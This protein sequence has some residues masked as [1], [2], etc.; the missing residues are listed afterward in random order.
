MNITAVVSYLR[1]FG[2]VG[3]CDLQ[4]GQ[5]GDLLIVQFKRLED[6]ETV[7]EKRYHRIQ[8]YILSVE[9][10]TEKASDSDWLVTKMTVPVQLLSLSEVLLSRIFD[11]LVIDD[12]CAVAETC[13]KFKQLSDPVFSSKFDKLTLRARDLVAS[14]AFMKFGH[15]ITDLDVDLTEPQSDYLDFIIDICGKNLRNLSLWMNGEGSA[16]L[17]RN[18]KKKLM[19]MLSHLQRLEIYCQKFFDSETMKDLFSSCSTLE[20]LSINSTSIADTV[21]NRINVRFP[22][23][24]ELKLHLNIAINDNGFGTLLASNPSIKKLYVDECTGLSSHAINIIVH[25]LPGLE[26]LTLGLLQGEC[27]NDIRSLGGLK[28]LKS[29]RILL[30]QALPAMNVV[31]EAGIQIESLDLWYIHLS[32]AHIARLSTMLSIKELSI[33]SSSL[34]DAHLKVIAEKLPLLTK[35]ML[36]Y[37]KHVT[38]DGLENMLLNAKRL[39]SLYLRNMKNIDEAGES[40]L[41]NVIFDTQ[42]MEGRPSIIIE[43][44]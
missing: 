6:V 10:F 33:F 32:D 19:W 3:H 16:P 26:E 1:T 21:W 4:R 18:T 5:S 17:N 39:S 24:N 37:S 7:L 9:L 20:S 38:I 2:E 28:C 13:T 34:E 22:Q 23:L 41:R 42:H 11:Y 12:L 40:H 8:K 44:V 36:G 30:G 29:L 14:K 31:Y 15:L 27:E 25:Y 35:L 43:N